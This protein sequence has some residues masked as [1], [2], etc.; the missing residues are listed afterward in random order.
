MP[1]VARLAPQGVGFDVMTLVMLLG[2]PN[3]SDQIMARLARREPA[4]S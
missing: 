3:R 2:P 1:G 4:P